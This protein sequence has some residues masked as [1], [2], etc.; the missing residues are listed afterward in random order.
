MPYR[1]GIDVGGTFT[2]IVLHETASGRL[3]HAKVPSTPDDPSWAMAAGIH[4]AAELA[5]IKPDRIGEV[6]HGTTV[7]TNAVLQR[8]GAK[9]ALVTTAGFEDLLEIGRQDRPSLYDLAATRP[10]PLVE[11]SRRVGAAVRMGS[12][13]AR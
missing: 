9:V 3:Y 4:T 5:R 10:P 7:A 12:R 13:S 11:R 6:G 8:A 2:D 1:I